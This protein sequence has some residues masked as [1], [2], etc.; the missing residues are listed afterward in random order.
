M[1]CP[2]G[3][4]GIRLWPLFSTS[5]AII[6]GPRTLLQPDLF[7]IPRDPAHPVQDWQ[8]VPVPLL[9]VEILIILRYKWPSN[10]DKVELTGAF[11]PALAGT[12][13]FDV[14]TVISR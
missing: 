4:G 6:L 11:I 2:L 14:R 12:P 1:H 3:R 8:K 5:R 13:C 7:V 9:A 10:S